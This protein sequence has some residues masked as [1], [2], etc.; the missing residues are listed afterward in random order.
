MSEWTPKTRR[1]VR[2]DQL[3]LSGEEGFV[4]AQLD[5]A[6][7][8]N[9]LVHMTG[10]GEG[11]VRQILDRLVTAGVVESA[12]ASTPPQPERSE[13]Q[14]AVPTRPQAPLPAARANPAQLQEIQDLLAEVTQDNIPLAAPDTAPSGKT[15]ASWDERDADSAE[16][17]PGERTEDSNEA[18]VNDTGLARSADATDEDAQDNG[19]ESD[20]ADDPAQ[21][22]SHQRL[23][24]ETLA[25]LD[26]GL[27]EAMAQE[28]SDPELAA[29]CFDPLPGVI[30]HIVENS[31]AGFSHARLIARHHRTPQGLDAVLARSDFR[32]DAQTQRL[33]LQNAM[34]QEPQL[35]RLLQPRRLA[36][37]YRVTISRDIPERTRQKARTVLRHKWA[38][39]DA[40]ERAGLVFQTEGR[41]LTQLTGLPFDSRTTSML[42][43]KT[44]A[45]NLLIQNLARFGATP[46]PVLAH[47]LKQQVV[48]RQ[49][50]L[51]TL[52]LQHPNC[53]SDAKRKA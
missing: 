39:S 23:Y 5:G 36:E 11:R 49:P 27:R 16:E 13:P 14:R 1:G 25:K 26:A 21:Q 37:I 43:A 18:S 8:V 40:E 33:L 52:I 22:A 47:L 35:V 2:L 53:P 3:N 46:P 6:T 9:H 48:R 19:S 45:S 31:H 28:A 42:C 41:C 32:R 38:T 4:L 12:G 34:L 29:L 7:S 51:R 50:V 30:R 17:M 10:L 24:M 44:Y 20:D 15:H